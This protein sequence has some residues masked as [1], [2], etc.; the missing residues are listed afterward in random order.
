MDDLVAGAESVEQAYNLY[1]RAKKIRVEAGMNLRKWSSND[2]MLMQRIRQAEGEPLLDNTS[3]EDY[4]STPGLETFAPKDNLS[5]KLLGLNWDSHDDCFKFDF[6]Q[7]LD[8]VRRLDPTKRSPL[9]ISAK[10]FDPLG[11]LSPFV[12]KLKLMFQG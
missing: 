4:Q 11:I 3:S 9:R 5:S 1:L 6:T 10:I 12:I 2:T 7:L 8:Y